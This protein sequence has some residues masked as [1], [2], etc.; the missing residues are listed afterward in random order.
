MKHTIASWNHKSACVDYSLAILESIDTNET[1]LKNEIDRLRILSV[2]FQ[3]ELETIH[4][5][6]KENETTNS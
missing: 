5:E 2:S 1:T 4:K 6:F 3:G